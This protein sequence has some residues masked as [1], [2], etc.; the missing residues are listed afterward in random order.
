MSEKRVVMKQAKSLY[1]SREVS[2]IYGTEIEIWAVVGLVVNTEKKNW[3]D[4]EQLRRAFFFML[5]WAK[6]NQIY[7]RKYCRVC[8]KKLHNWKVIF[9]FFLKK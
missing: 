8:A 3:A 1:I 4:Y 2:N 9:F 6:K 7:F 5:S